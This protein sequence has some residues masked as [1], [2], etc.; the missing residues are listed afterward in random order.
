MACSCLSQVQFQKWGWDFNMAI[1]SS[2]S[3]LG[4][5]TGWKDKFPYLFTLQLVKSAYPFTVTLLQIVMVS[6]DT[7]LVK[8]HES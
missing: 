7:H 4:L 5:C 3:P 2:V 8:N 6:P 1:N